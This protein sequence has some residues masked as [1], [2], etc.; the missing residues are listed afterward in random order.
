MKFNRHPLRLAAI[1]NDGIRVLSIMIWT[2]SENEKRQNSEYWKTMQFMT[3]LP[4]SQCKL[5]QRKTKNKSIKMLI[6]SHCRLVLMLMF[7]TPT[8][9]FYLARVR[10]I[11]KLE[12]KM[13]P[14][15]LSAL[16]P[17]SLWLC[18]SLW[19]LSQVKTRLEI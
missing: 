7:L 4:I 14:L 12:E 6:F 15:F 9:Q 2:Y 8:V 17:S 11:R 16:I 5:D 3:P 1:T 10:V 13:S 18:S 19:F